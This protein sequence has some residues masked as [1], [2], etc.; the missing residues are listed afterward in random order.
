MIYNS[1][2]EPEYEISD[3]YPPI[4]LLCGNTARFDYES[5]I[6]YRCETCFAVVGSIGMPRVCQELYE[7]EKV[8][9]TL[10]K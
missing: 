1:D 3:R 5:G 6:S 9:E 2:Y 10:S 7:K 4:N 8:W